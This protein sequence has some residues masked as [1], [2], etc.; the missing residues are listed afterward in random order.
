MHRRFA[1]IY[2]YFYHSRS[3]WNILSMEYG[4]STSKVAL[5]FPKIPESG[6]GKNISNERR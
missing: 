5:V 1:L 4:E 6:S 2:F 3:Y